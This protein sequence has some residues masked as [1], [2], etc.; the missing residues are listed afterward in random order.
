MHPDA[1]AYM[2]DNFT[3]EGDVI[4]DPFMG[5]GTTGMVATEKNRSFVGIE[6]DEVYFDL[7]KS[8]IM[9]E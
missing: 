9:D 7:C 5:V 8:N 4:L 2:I 3:K 6:L 1:C